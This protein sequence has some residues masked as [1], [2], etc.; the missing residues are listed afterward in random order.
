MAQFSFQFS[1]TLLKV[2]CREGGYTSKYCDVDDPYKQQRA[3]CNK[4]YTENVHF[5]IALSCILK[6]FSKVKEFVIV[7]CLTKNPF[8][9]YPDTTYSFVPLFLI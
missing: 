4:Q 6:V 3:L 5:A 8:L 1:Q 9:R 2:I 7:Y